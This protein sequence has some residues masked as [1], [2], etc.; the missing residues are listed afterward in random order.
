MANFFGVV[1]TGITELLTDRIY[2]VGFSTVA[3]AAPPQWQTEKLAGGDLI[4][5]L[6]HPGGPSGP[7]TEETPSAITTADCPGIV[8][9]SIGDDFYDTVV[10]IAR[11]IDAGKVITT[12]N[13]TVEIYNAYR[14]IARSFISFT[15]NAG[16]G[17]S[18][19]D[20]PALPATINAQDNLLL[21]LEV[22]TVGPPFIDGDLDYEFDTITISIPLTGQRTNLF[23]FRPEGDIEEVLEFETDVRA[24]KGGSEQRASLRLAPRQVFQML[25]RQ[26]GFDRQAL[27]A[28]MVDAQ[29]RIFGLPM[30]HEPAKLASPITATDVT[31]TVDSTAYADYRN[32]SLAMKSGFAN[33]FPTGVFVMPVRLA[34]ATGAPR[35]GKYPLNLQDTKITF[36][37]LDND[38]DLADTSAFPTF[39]SK[40][41]LDEANMIEG[42]VLSESLLRPIS[43]IDSMAGLFEIFTEV[44]ITRRTSSKTFFS[45]T[46]QRL[47]EVR[48]LLH[49]LRGRQVSFY[50]PT[51]FDEFIVT[52]NVTSGSSALNFENIGYTDFIQSRQPYDVIRLVKTDGT[53]V[54]RNVLSS[55]ELSET[56]EQITVDAAWGVNATIAEIERVDFIEKVRFD[57]DNIRITHRN[58]RGDAVIRGPVVSVLD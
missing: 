37:T 16:A 51:F 33:S 20:L 3:K 17:V 22:T 9:Y 27:Q 10:I 47:W 56:E 30:W 8:K 18:I 38:V 52:A 26:D 5:A 13:F 25:F 53:K 11:S 41:L 46:R 29:A 31:I 6:E 58:S 55:S 45:R 28:L 43:T 12:Q 50:L 54:I 44:D 35:G 40:V 39:N 19:T 42:A 21:T 24:K 49:A 23:V 36:K 32:D 2:D 34:F 14:S 15:N 48:Q 57:S 1:S 7:V 4:E